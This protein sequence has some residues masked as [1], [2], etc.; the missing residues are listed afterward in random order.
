MSENAQ[1]RVA[2]EQDQD[3]DR[4]KSETAHI[5][6]A[7]P[8]EDITIPIFVVRVRVVQIIVF[9]HVLRK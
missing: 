2:N 7:P 3:P 5:H 4:H 8:V 6:Q 1:H 9:L